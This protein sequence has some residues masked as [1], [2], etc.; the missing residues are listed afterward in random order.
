MNIGEKY[1]RNYTWMNEFFKFGQGFVQTRFKEIITK[2]IIFFSRID[3]SE[4]SF[5][6]QNRFKFLLFYF[7]EKKP[8]IINR[9]TRY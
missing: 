2:W 6:K 9:K 4:I 7:F 1:F 5:E 8:E 3:K